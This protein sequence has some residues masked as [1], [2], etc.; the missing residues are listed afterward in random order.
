[1]KPDKPALWKRMLKK[2]RNSSNGGEKGRWSAKKS[3]LAQIGYAQKGGK[4][5]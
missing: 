3:I 2:A 1:M 5:K 4:W